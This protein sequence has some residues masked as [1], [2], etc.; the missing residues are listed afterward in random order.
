MPII[1]LTLPGKGQGNKTLNFYNNV[2]NV[3]NSIDYALDNMPGCYGEYEGV[4]DCIACH[5]RLPC[6][7]MSAGGQE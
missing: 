6:A 2:Y 5:L 3:Y 1:K 7:R 4:G